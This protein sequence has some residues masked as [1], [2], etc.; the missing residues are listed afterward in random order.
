MPLYD[1]QCTECRNIHEHYAHIEERI[2]TCE[3]C[4]GLM[5][6]MIGIGQNVIG[7]ID[8]VTDNITGK[9]IRITSRKQLRG[10]L[11]KHGLYEKYGKGWC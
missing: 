2:K 8:F 3:T 6:R 4:G 11:K 1:F 9:P 5:K 10:L 7:D